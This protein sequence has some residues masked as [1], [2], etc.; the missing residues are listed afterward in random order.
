MGKGVSPLGSNEVVGP[1][2]LLET[3]ASLGLQDT[4][5]APFS[6]S[7]SGCSFGVLLG[8]CPRAH[9]SLDFPL[10]FSSDVHFLD[11]LVQSVSLNTIY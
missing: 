10:W 2:P 4:A 8:H 1:S 9:S 3:P 7:L 6:S 11:D 5:P